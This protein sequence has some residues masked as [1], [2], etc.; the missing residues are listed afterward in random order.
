MCQVTFLYNIMLSAMVVGPGQWSVYLSLNI[1][2][3]L[4]TNMIF[5]ADKTVL[6][7]PKRDLSNNVA[8]KSSCMPST[9]HAPYTYG[10]IH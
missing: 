8:D 1:S 6:S 10:A 9:S 3:A 2:M 4:P 5:G 7:A